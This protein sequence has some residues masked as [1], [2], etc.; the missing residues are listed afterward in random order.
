M[1]AATATWVRTCPPDRAAAT[2]E[3]ASRHFFFSL[4]LCYA[5]VAVIGFVPSLVG[6][7]RGTF[8]MSGPA[9]LHGVLMVSW[10]AVLVAQ[11]ALPAR[12]AVRQH[13]RLGAW[14]AALAVLI[15]VSLLV[16]TARS[17]IVNDPQPGDFVYNILLLQGMVLLLFPL[18]FGWA[19]ARRRSPGWHKRLMVI[20]A[21][22][23]LQA[24][25]DRMF[26]LPRGDGSQWENFVYLDLLLVPLLLFDVKTLGRIH[27]ATAIGA[28]ILVGVQLVALQ[29]WNSPAWHDFA[30]AITLGL[31]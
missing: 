23:P 27:P 4:M 12:G 2:R 22:L 6:F 14:A 28:A 15:W 11:S 24:S 31:R 7:A 9:H 20:T 19:F 3:G 16:M 21:L 17:I 1:L 5:V 10:L 30:H 18:F 26:W 29:L 25:I 8:P 13:Q